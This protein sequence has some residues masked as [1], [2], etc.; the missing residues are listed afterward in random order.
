MTVGQVYRKIF[1]G[2]SYSSFDEAMFVQV[3]IANPQI[4]VDCSY[5]DFDK[6]LRKLL[7][8]RIHYCCLTVT[9]TFVL[10]TSYMIKDVTELLYQLTIG[11]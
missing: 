9:M 11:L 10:A 5:T 7:L 6:L 4:A 8:W 3:T 1:Y 2:D